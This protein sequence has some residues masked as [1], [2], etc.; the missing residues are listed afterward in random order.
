MKVIAAL[1]LV[2]L[3][4]PGCQKILEFYKPDNHPASL[5]CRLKSYSYDYFGSHYSTT[6]KYDAKGNPILITY[7]DVY[8][9]DGKVTES[10][11]Y[12]SL[13]R[14]VLHEPDPGMGNTRVYVYE[15]NYRTPVRDTVKG[16]LGDVY[17]ESFERDA[18]GRITRE[19]IELLKAS[20]DSG[21]WGFKTEVYRYY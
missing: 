12:D 8:L 14:L 5:A 2:V 9:P 3:I 21:D 10:F 17:L 6:F 1:V 13:G 7:F 16:S 18:A 20:E 11:T 15:G 19:K 4:F